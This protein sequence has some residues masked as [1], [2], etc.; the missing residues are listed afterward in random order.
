MI[1]VSAPDSPTEGVAPPVITCKVTLKGRKKT[2]KCQILSGNMYL[3][4]VPVV[5]VG[6]RAVSLSWT[7]VL[8]SEGKGVDMPL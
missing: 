8:E 4:L 1:L 6:L 7:L 2:N 5:V 3:I